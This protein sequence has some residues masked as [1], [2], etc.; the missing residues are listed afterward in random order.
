MLE[1][2]FKRFIK[3]IKYNPESDCWEWQGWLAKGYGRLYIKE[4]D[5]E[6][7]AS[8]FAYWYFFK[9]P[10]SKMFI[11][12][13]CDNRK[14]VNPFHLF[15]GTQS[16]NMVDKIKKGRDHYASRTH[17]KNGHEFTESNTRL[18]RGNARRCLAC[19]NEKSNQWRI[20]NMEY[21]RRYARERYQ[22]MYK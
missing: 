11:C 20:K 5:T 10:S 2:V 19:S 6:I 8:R 14:C 13:S 16:E 9:K 18:R 4:L 12:H 21:F 15:E 7:Q 3:K 22:R 17:C 1:R